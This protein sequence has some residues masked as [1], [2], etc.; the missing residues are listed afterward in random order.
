MAISCKGVPSTNQPVGQVREIHPG[1]E[2][3]EA[4][5]RIYG[6]GPQTGPRVALGSQ[7]LRA[8]ALRTPRDTAANCEVPFNRYGEFSRSVG[9][10]HVEPRWVAPSEMGVTG[11]PCC[12]VEHGHVRLAGSDGVDERPAGWT[13]SFCALAPTRARRTSANISASTWATALSLFVPVEWSSPSGGQRESL[14][15]AETG[16]GGSGGKPV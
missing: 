1:Q 2:A 15:G 3:G 10:V 6:V 9:P 5:E 14:R 12:R 4:L 8:P 16:G 11:F 13:P 7:D